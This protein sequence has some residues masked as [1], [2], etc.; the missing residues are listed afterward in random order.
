MPI[1]KM[2]GPPRRAILCFG[3]INPLVC[4]RGLR[5]MGWVCFWG[6]QPF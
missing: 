6:R 1:G 4:P 5:S 3:S 2:M